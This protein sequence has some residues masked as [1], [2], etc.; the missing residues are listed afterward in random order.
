M[1]RS[2]LFIMVGG[3]LVFVASIMFLI[4]V[5]TLLKDNNMV[6]SATIVVLYVVNIVIGI[7]GE[8]FLR[9]SVATVFEEVGNE[10]GEA[11]DNSAK[12]SRLVLEEFENLNN[13]VETLRHEIAGLKQQDRFIV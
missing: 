8:G 3:M 7:I 2:D 5:W 10:I 13:K 6:V 9:R 4:V 1:Q 12:Q 11:V